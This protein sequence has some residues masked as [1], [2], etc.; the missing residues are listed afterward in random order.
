[1]F[2]QNNDTCCFFYVYNT[3]IK[4]VYLQYMDPFFKEMVDM[5]TDSTE[6]KECAILWGLDEDPYILRQRKDLP[7]TMSRTIHS[8]RSRHTH[9]FPRTNG[10]SG[11]FPSARMTKRHLKQCNATI[12]P[13]CPEIF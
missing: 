8:D 4:T 2:F 13:I 6:L 10:L 5:Y 12:I 7:F 1:M 9:T 3:I 11:S